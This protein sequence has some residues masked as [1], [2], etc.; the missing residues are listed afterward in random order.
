[1][2]SMG[3]DQSSWWNETRADREARARADRFSRSLD[4]WVGPGEVLAEPRGEPKCSGG[5]SYAEQM[6]SLVRTP[7]TRAIGTVVCSLETI[8]EQLVVRYRDIT[9]ETSAQGKGLARS[10]WQHQM[11]SYRE[12]GAVA[13]VGRA[14][15]VG[16]YLWATCGFQIANGIAGLPREESQIQLRNI[17]GASCECADLLASWVKSDEVDELRAA[18]AVPPA[19][20]GA[21]ATPGEL[22]RHGAEGLIGGRATRLG[23]ELLVRV[24]WESVFRL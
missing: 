7:S 11:S 14:D 16:S 19:E 3:T 1:M 13:V 6:W 9:I 15:K 8:D 12:L 2:E 17:L 18:L 4:D 21:I 23:Q 20:E 5:G 22:S 24:S 10:L